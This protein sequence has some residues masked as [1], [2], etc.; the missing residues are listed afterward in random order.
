MRKLTLLFTSPPGIRRQES[1]RRARLTARACAHPCPTRSRATRGCT[2]S[3]GWPVPIQIDSRAAS[4]ASAYRMRNRDVGSS[5]ISWLHARICER[6]MPKARGHSW[7]FKTRFR[8]HAF[9][10][11]SQPA[12][13]RL[14][15]A[16]SEVKQV[17]RLE[18]VLAAEARSRYSNASRRRWSTSTARPAQSAAPSIAR[19]PSSCQSLPARQRT[20]ARGPH[21]SIACSRPTPRTR[22]RTSSGSPNT[23]R[24]RRPEPRDE[25][26][27]A[28][29]ANRACGL[30]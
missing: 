30:R 28:R 4:R 2:A 11:K 17:A 14:Q 12:I 7:R 10:W 23:G 18:P 29:C 20:P 24:S 21:G 5:S 27:R 26:P 8:R 9:G 3:R 19:S 6:H 25:V 1:I 22:S 13:T 16:L 15:E